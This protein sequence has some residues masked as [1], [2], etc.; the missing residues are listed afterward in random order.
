[1]KN[2]YNRLSCYFLPS[3]LKYSVSIFCLL[4]IP[5]FYYFRHSSPLFRTGKVVWAV[6]LGCA[7]VIVHYFSGTVV[8][9]AGFGISL[10]MCGFL[11]YVGLP[12]LLPIIVCLLFVIIRVFPAEVDF[13]GFSL[14]W[15]IPVSA[16]SS[17]EWNS[18]GYP[19]L[20]VLVPVLWSGL[21]VGIPLFIGII[22]RHRRWFI[23]TFSALGILALVFA[24]VTAWWAFYSQQT[25]A[26]FLFLIASI[27]PAV[28]SLLRDFLHK[29]YTILP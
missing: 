17:I 22:M 9:P 11:D 20:L 6:L 7:A 10:W 29:P 26:G 5:L 15:L 28:I 14:V 25:L 19:V 4:W 16:Y 8:S 27:I 23:I 3:K 1:M 12:V 21:A 13:A 24:A 18:P 2:Q